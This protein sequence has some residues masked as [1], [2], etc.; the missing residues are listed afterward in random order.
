MATPNEK[1]P[2]RLGRGLEALL[3]AN[4]VQR[5][6]QPPVESAGG[7]LQQIPLSLIQVNPFQPRKKFNEA[8]LGELQTSL[9]AHGLIQPITVRR[10]EQG[11]GFELISG[12]R[13][14]RAAQRLGWTEIP[15]LVREADN[16]TSLTVALIENLQRAD[17]N[18]VEEAEGYDRLS[19]EFKLDQQQ[20]AE[21]VGKDRSTIANAT[22]LLSLPGEI[23]E[24]LRSG[25]MS[26]GH[27]RPLIGLPR[28]RSIPLASEIIDLQLSVR[29]VE[30]R[31]REDMSLAPPPS[32][33]KPKR[34][35]PRKEPTSS[36]EAK[37]IE[38]RLRRHF[39][40]DVAIQLHKADQGEIRIRF[41]SADDMDRLLQLMGLNELST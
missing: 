27:A 6:S 34:G 26:A 5:S 8:E 18:P 4:T 24:H 29:E 35:R 1:A 12:E 41:Y 23:L 17:L 36:S 15:A 11:E 38:Q 13:R 7:G 21:I 28:A 30:R 25:A 32:A 33:A 31:L 22:R 20:V 10:I 14:F 9:G 3:S 37:A 19:K 39:Q 16:R 2:K 40:T